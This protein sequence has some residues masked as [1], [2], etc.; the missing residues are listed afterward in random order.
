MEACPYLGGRKAACGVCRS[1][2]F[3]HEMRQQ[4]ARIMRESGPLQKPYNSRPD[5]GVRS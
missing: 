5:P 1:N 3:Q 4:F 2:F